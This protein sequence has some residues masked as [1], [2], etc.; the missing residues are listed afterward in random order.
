VPHL[1]IKLS[2]EDAVSVMDEEAVAVVNRD[3]FTQLLKG[4]CR[5][6]MRVTLTWRI[7]RPA[8]STTTQ[9]KSHAMIARTWLWTKGRQRWNET[10]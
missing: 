6:G 8:C 4:P 2:G 5:G 10:R 7:L 1:L 9:Q 3:G